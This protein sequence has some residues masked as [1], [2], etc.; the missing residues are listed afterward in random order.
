MWAVSGSRRRLE[1]ALVCQ[2]YSV[3]YDLQDNE[4]QD[5]V[6]DRS[7]RFFMTGRPYSP[8]FLSSLIYRVMDD[9]QLISTELSCKVNLLGS[10]LA[11]GSTEENTAF[12][13]RTNVGISKA[14]CEMGFTVLDTALC[15]T[16]SS[17]GTAPTVSSSRYQSEH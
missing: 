8:T 17:A 15:H 10:L 9:G 3:I 4:S 11:A 7:P 6:E 13:L 5:L 1:D 12:A 14:H 2:R 16:P